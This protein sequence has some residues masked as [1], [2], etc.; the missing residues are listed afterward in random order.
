MLMGSE[1]PKPASLPLQGRV[2]AVAIAAAV[3]VLTT[4]VPYLML[5]NVLFLGIF[6][7]GLLSVY[8]AV[9]AFQV[10]LSYNEAFFLGGSGGFVGGVVSELGSY[11]LIELAGYRPG[12]ETVLLLREWFLS[13]SGG[14]PELKEYVTREFAAQLAPVKPTLL[15]LFLGTVELAMICSAVAG[16]GGMLI[17]FIL[18]RQ[19]SRGR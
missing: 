7:A 14:D 4:L 5:V 10:R 2:R 16:L 11:L 17:V 15:G 3:I 12:T 13:M 1:Q 18:K 8:Y 6:L 9:I 19:A